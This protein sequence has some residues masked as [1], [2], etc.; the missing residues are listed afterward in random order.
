M[1]TKTEVKHTPGPW[2]VSIH[3]EN[4]PLNVTYKLFDSPKSLAEVHANVS[5]IAAA[6][7]LLEAAKS[8]VSFCENDPTGEAL[9]FL[10]EIKAAIAKA[11]VK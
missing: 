6:P 2:L 10:K 11:V 9:L 4:D 1:T 7:K 8:L 5:L 3:S